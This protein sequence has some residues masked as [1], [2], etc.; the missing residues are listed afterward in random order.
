MLRCGNTAD[1]LI[2]ASGTEPPMSR[3][4]KKNYLRGKAGRKSFPTK[5][6]RGAREEGTTSSAKYRE[7]KRQRKTSGSGP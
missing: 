5:D 7:R 1:R 3:R 2:R 6:V 4:R